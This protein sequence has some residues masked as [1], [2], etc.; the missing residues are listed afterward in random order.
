[1]LPP[2]R[3]YAHGRDRIKMDRKVELE[4]LVERAKVAVMN[5]QEWLRVIEENRLDGERPRAEKALFETLD[6]LSTLLRE[7]AEL[8]P[9]DDDSAESPR[10][11]PEAADEV[12]N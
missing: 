5:C 2:I 11:R 10:N 6:Q 8:A 12:E 9:S 1:M 7:L 4:S 3:V